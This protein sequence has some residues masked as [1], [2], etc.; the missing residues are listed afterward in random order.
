MPAPRA[1]LGPSYNKAVEVKD[2]ELVFVCR[3]V[4]EEALNILY[5]LKKVILELPSISF[6]LEVF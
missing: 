1:L 6:R 4:V 3:V 5:E 2:R